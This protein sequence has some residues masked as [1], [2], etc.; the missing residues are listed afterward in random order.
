MSF[1]KAVVV[2][3]LGIGAT[4]GAY[5]SGATNTL[6]HSTFAQNLTSP[7]G[8]LTAPLVGR[9]LMLRVQTDGSESNA[10]SPRY[11]VD[12]RTGRA[13]FVSFSPSWTGEGSNPGSPVISGERL[14]LKPGESIGVSPPGGQQQGF[15]PSSDFRRNDRE[16]APYRDER[17]PPDE[18]TAPPDEGTGPPDEGEGRA[19][20][21]S[22]YWTSR[23]PVYAIRSSDVVSRSYDDSGERPDGYSV[24]DPSNRQSTDGDAAPDTRD[25]AGPA[26][27]DDPR[28]FN[29]YGPGDAQLPEQTDTSSGESGPCDVSN[30][31]TVELQVNDCTAAGARGCGG[32]QE[33]VEGDR[34]DER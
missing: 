23:A 4:I 14:A 9:P 27:R 12:N 26:T 21:P 10:C 22:S 17:T 2:F 30:R 28:N 34:G 20:N 5:L 24:F 16:Q 1:I 13:L 15:S 6:A 18:S 7:L 19:V 32:Q 29:G 31:P 25:D 11:I 8:S 3:L 33:I